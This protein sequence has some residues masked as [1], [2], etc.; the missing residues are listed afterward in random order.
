MSVRRRASG[1]VHYNYFRDYDPAIGRY[2]ESDPIGLHGGINTYAYALDNPVKYGDPRGLVV[3]RCCRKA[4][5]AFGLVSHCYLKTDT[6]TAGMNAGP[7]CS[8]AGDNGSDMPWI[9]KTYVSDHS[10]ET[11]GSCTTMPDVDES[12]VNKELE[13]GRYLGRFG[14]TNNCQSFAIQTLSKCRKR[15]ETPWTEDR[16]LDYQGY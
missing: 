11:G 8:L 15:K 5:V 10:C 4:Q 16:L 13:I 3:Q 1:R 9:T 12:C 2:V 14:V 7:R 6:K